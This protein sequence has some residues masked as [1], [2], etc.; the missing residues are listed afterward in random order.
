[1]R[2]LEEWLSADAQAFASQN[3]AYRPTLHTPRLFYPALFIDAPVLYRA[4][5]LPRWHHAPLPPASPL[6]SHTL[7]SSTRRSA[8]AARI[9]CRPAKQ[10][11]INMQQGEN[12]TSVS[13]K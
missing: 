13:N 2:V 4:A 11:A 1:M 8:R 12:R 5:G 10:F 9:S 7:A 6:F 3:P